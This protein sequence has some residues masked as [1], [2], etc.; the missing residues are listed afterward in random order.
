M[1]L[2]KLEDKF[3]AVVEDV[4]PSVVSVYTTIMT[5]IDLFRVAPVQGMGSGVIV[6]EDG[7]IITNAHV[8]RNAQKIGIQLH[9][10]KKMDAK[11]IGMMRGLDIAVLELKE[12]DLDPITIGN[13]SDL[14]VGQFAIAVGNPLGLG[15]SVTFGLVSALNRN[16]NAQN[17]QLEGLIQTTAEI[18]PG[19][20]GGAL[21]NTSAELIGI[22]TAVIPFSQGIGFA[23]AIDSVKGLLENFRETGS[24]N[25]PWIGITG[26]TIDPRIANYYQ[27]THDKGALI[28]QVPAGPAKKA[29]IKPGDIIIGINDEEINS[30][31]IL[32]QKIVKRRIGEEL[33]VKYIRKGR[34][35]E[36][37]VKLDKAPS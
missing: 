20:S 1:T 3:V 36:T 8:V 25:T 2:D 22:P 6:E 18:N 30:I 34:E 31:Q 13:S 7:I 27:L 32:I 9:G 19:N 11:V 28:I 14:K 33:K 23:I 29:G 12:K 37:Y 15:E 16:I 35:Y 5:R 17:A 10:G 21:V 26:Y 24:V 4:L